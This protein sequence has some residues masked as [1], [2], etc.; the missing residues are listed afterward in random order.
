VMYKSFLFWKYPLPIN[1]CYSGFVA[2]FIF[3]YFICAH[4]FHDVIL[5]YMELI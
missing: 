1:S 2:V 4:W 5:G 3:F